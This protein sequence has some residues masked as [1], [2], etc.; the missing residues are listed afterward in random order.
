MPF[1]FCGTD[2]WSSLGLVS[3][4]R[5]TTGGCREVEIIAAGHLKQS[6]MIAVS[7]LVP[8]IITRL[9]LSSPS[10]K[11]FLPVIP[12]QLFV[13]LYSGLNQELI[14][15]KITEGGV[16]NYYSSVTETFQ[17][18]SWRSCTESCTS[19]VSRAWE[20][21]APRTHRGGDEE[22]SF[23][24]WKKC[25]WKHS[26]SGPSTQRYLARDERRFQLCNVHVG[27]K[28]FISW[29]SFGNTSYV[30]KNK[31]TVLFNAFV[32]LSL[33]SLLFPQGSCFRTGSH[34]G[35]TNLRNGWALWMFVTTRPRLQFSRIC[36]NP[37]V[38]GAVLSAG[39]GKQS[40]LKI[41]QRVAGDG[42]SFSHP[43]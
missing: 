9:S 39:S 16:G 3:C 41:T 34:G 17:S 25:R 19:T 2:L 32:L 30:Q 27:S 24:F 4:I 35:N 7:R 33:N 29:S 26:F 1:H 40:K 12:T 36:A 37:A 5:S 8:V 20:S 43:M 14:R 42:K 21:T 13:C 31:G 11:H 23:C 28:R 15:L 18:A 38:C 10:L 6:F 22:R